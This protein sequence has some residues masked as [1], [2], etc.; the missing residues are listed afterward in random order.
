MHGR[1]LS[2]SRESAVSSQRLL[3][4]LIEAPGNGL[5]NSLSVQPAFLKQFS[6]LSVFHKPIR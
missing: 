2:N 5:A 4:Q 3:A 6:V 1:S